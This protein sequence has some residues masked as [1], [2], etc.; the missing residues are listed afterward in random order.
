MTRLE[1]LI[2][3]LATVIICYHDSQ[4]F[5][6]LVREA[7]LEEQL[8][9][10]REKAKQLILAKSPTFDKSLEALIEEC[11]QSYPLR[12]PLLF[13]IAEQIKFLK[14][15]Q[16]RDKSFSSET[17]VGYK[18]EITRMLIDFRNLLV[19][20][21][22]KTY[23]VKYCA[24]TPENGE[25]PPNKI[26]SLSGLKN[27][28]M[29]GALLCR[30]GDLLKDEVLKKF[31]IIVDVTKD[32]A[33]KEP[34]PEI[35][36]QSD[37]FCNE[38]QNALLVPELLLK[39]T[40]LQEQIGTRD[41]TITEVLQPKLDEAASKIMEQTATIES[42][43]QQLKE[44]ESKPTIQSQSSEALA[45]AEEHIKALALA[46]ERIKALE[47]AQQKQEEIIQ[48]Q[49]ETI[50]KHETQE[51]C[52]RLRLSPYSNSFFGIATANFLAQQVQKG[53]ASTD[54]LSETG[55]KTQAITSPSPFSTTVE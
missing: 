2:Y 11:T 29:F 19:T 7:T 25:T 34:T 22:S 23:D 51:L 39:N 42:L 26:I 48:A 18:G 38:H 13:Y 3:S 14:S 15:L 9:K 33:V 36:E 16:N 37:I 46:E 52:A 20:V 21:K 12:K 54:T 31:N 53:R 1:D 32:S 6:P 4:G 27:D 47:I 8:R 49:K 50:S 35:L 44:A 10:S 30:S 24:I 55:T 17:L 40:L 45:L 5:N 28:A 43:N 41:R